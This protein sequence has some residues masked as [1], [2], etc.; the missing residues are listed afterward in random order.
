M[1]KRI[2]IFLFI[3]FLFMQNFA[4]IKTSTFGI[5]AL[6]VF[7][8]YLTLKY[9]FYFRIDFRFLMSIIVIISIALISMV[10]NQLYDITQ[11]IRLLMIIFV[12][13]STSKYIHKI[14]SM[15]HSRYFWRCFYL[16]TLVTCLY[17]IYQFFA[18]QHNL[19]LFLNIFN[20]NP[21]YTPRGVYDYYGG[22]TDSGSRV[23][24]IF[25]EPSFYGI[26]LSYCFLILFFKPYNKIK[27]IIISFLILINIAVTYSR[28]AWGILGYSVLS[29]FILTVLKKIK[30]LNR[31][32]SF[33]FIFIPFMNLFTMYKLQQNTFTDLSSYSRT[34]SAIY[35]L[36]NSYDTVLHFLFGHGLGSISVE[37][38]G[39]YM[40]MYVENYSHNGYAEILYC[41]GF[42]ALTF[43]IIILM[44]TINTIKIYKYRIIAFVVI[45]TI[46]IFESSYNIESIISL[47]TILFT[48]SQIKSNGANGLECKKRRKLRIVWG[49]Q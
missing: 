4:L 30:P 34:F 44:K 45:F 41:I 32:F 36:K 46:C 27:T 48:I 19:P 31:F 26:F 42:P 18:S 20:N 1:V 29:L 15:G 24:A 33:I 14:Y 28:S 47:V 6:T 43:I 38:P 39:K 21:S 7:L 37:T 17:G 3:L 23:Y 2:E 35:Y 40:Q 10:I 12:V 9:G 11:I 49:K 13:W 22:W 16:V 25:S 8:I 5:S